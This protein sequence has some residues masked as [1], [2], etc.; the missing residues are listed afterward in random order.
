MI[1]IS[2]EI[3]EKYVRIILNSYFDDV[4]ETSVHYNFKCNVCGDSEHDEFKKRGYILKTNNP[5]VYY[6]HNCHES[7]TVIKWMKQH[8][9]VQYKNMMIDIMRNNKSVE[10]QDYNFKIKKCASER[11]ERLDTIGFKKLTKFDDC[12][13]YCENRKIPKEIYSNWFYCTSGIFYG[14]IIITFRD[15]FGKIY[16]YQGRSF[17]NKNGVK[18]LTRFGE[19]NSIYNY[20][21]VDKSKPVPVLEGPIDSDFVENSIAVMGLKVG[22]ELLN[23]FDHLYFL[24]DYDKSGIEMSFKLLKKYR[25]WVFNWAKF[26]KDY[27]CD[28]VNLK[29]DVNEF[30][31]KNKRGI[32]KLTW[33]IISPYFTN[34]VGDLIYFI[35]KK[36]K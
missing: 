27:P 17:N 34:N 14:R 15:N 2:T 10:Q 12:V 26:L 25:K 1:N 29:M 3:L 19:H 5:W 33:D 11:D 13:K 20:Y 21:N 6:C 32:Q 22:D 18:Y 28:G 9:V 30:I 24:L 36:N 35:F 7:T 8:F 4:F 16:N 23:T 31:L